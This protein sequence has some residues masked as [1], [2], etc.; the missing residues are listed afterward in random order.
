LLQ[1]S[2]RASHM[3]THNISRIVSSIV[4]RVERSSHKDFA[5]AHG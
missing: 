1:T 3:V 5:T 4:E 2:K